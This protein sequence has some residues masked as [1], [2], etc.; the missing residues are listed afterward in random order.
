MNVGV[1]VGVSVGM[2]VM[3]GVLVEVGK[4]VNVCVAAAPAVWAMEVLMERRS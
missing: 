1:E 3:V 2:T 4:R